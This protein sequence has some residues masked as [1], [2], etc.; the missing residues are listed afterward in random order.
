[1][2]S[3]K[4][5]KYKLDIKE[6]IKGEAL[7]ETFFFQKHVYYGINIFLPETYMYYRQK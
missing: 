3:I 7:P 6:Y 2:F 1:M 4:F 5:Y